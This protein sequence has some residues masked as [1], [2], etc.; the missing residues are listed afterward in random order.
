VRTIAI[1][2]VK[3]LQRAKT[4]LAG[5]LRPEERATLTREMLAHV[6]AAISESGVVDCTGVI[7]PAPE[8]LD[9][10]SGAIGIRQEREGL[11]NVLEQGREWAE[12]ERAA[13]LLII[14]ADLPLLSPTD[15]TSLVE[16]GSDDNTVVLCP[17]RRDTGTNLML[18]HPPPVARFHFGE[19]SY[20]KHLAAAIQAGARVHTYRSTGTGLDIDTIED[21]EEMLSV[22]GS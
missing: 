18:A 8:T 4:R 20:G 10:P 22:V 13:A 12:G 7:S 6:L 5:H 3:D 16:L 17:D 11:N 15:I 2:P 19:E 21:L 1:V 14:F 9:L